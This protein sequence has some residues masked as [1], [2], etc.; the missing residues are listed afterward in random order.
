MGV[1]I[2]G[3]KFK[4]YILLC[5]FKYFSSFDVFGNHLKNVKNILS[6]WVVGKQMASWIWPYKGYSLPTPALDQQLSALAAHQ[7][8]LGS[9]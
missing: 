7:G 4:F 8:H 5:V 3:C 9:L 2:H 6:L 1:L